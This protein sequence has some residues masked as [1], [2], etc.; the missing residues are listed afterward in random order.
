LEG[1][2]LAGTEINEKYKEVVE[3]IP[4]VERLYISEPDAIPGTFDL[5]TLVHVL[6]HVANPSAL[7]KRLSAKL[8]PHGHILIEVP[9]FI[10]SP[11]D[12]LVA[13]HCTHFTPEALAALL[14]RVGYGIDAIPT[15][16]VPKELSLL[17]HYNPGQAVAPAE[18]ESGYR[19]VK[20]SIG[21]L[22]AVVSAARSCSE[23]SLFGLFGTS[24]AGTWLCSEIDECVSFF[25][26]EDPGRVGRSHLGRP[27]YHPR[28]VP[29]GSRVF[30]AMPPAQA[31]IVG[32]RLAQ[33]YKN[34][35]LCL[36]P[37]LIQ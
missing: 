5:I 18:Q 4:H 29:D 37:L 33:T 30:V 7:L 36:P 8:A 6:E 19:L 2:V 11:F 28:D 25:V 10:R 32:E 9:T 24:L 1:W 13:D 3:Q 22:E 26:D 27:I 17:G 35:R 14:Q 15:E 12:L 16:W 20:R 31:K 23:G 34:F 21:W